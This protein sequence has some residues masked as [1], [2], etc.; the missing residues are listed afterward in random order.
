MKNLSIFNQSSFSQK[1]WHLNGYI[2]HISLNTINIFCKIPQLFRFAQITLSKWYILPSQSKIYKRWWF[3][4]NINFAPKSIMECITKCRNINLLTFKSCLKSIWF[5][6]LNGHEPLSTFNRALI[7]M[8][9]G[10]VVFTNML[11]IH[12]PVTILD[13]TISK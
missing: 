11:K 13:I 12:T 9:I 10:F 7:F 3:L 4:S 6:S 5:E 1:S 2:I 8:T